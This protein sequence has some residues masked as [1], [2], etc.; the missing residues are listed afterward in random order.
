LPV[1]A[2]ALI[3]VVSIG[4]GG[5]GGS[6]SAGNQAEIDAANKARSVAENRATNAVSEARTKVQAELADR[7]AALDTRGAELNER[8][9]K[10]T[11]LE[12]AA[13]ANT[14]TGDGVYEV[15]VDIQPGKW[16]TSGS[17]QSCYWELTSKGGDI[18]DN[19]NVSGPTVI[20]IPASAF[21]FTTTRCG[22]WNKTG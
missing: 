2:L 21:S 1:W 11:K 5:A 15:G 8:E 16:K 22:T 4:L 13:K 14:I 6:S 12:E 18:I 7:E 9:Q 19:D 10:V 20:V 17:G 3:V